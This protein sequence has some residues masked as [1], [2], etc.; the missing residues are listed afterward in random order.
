MTKI[1][2]AIV[3]LCGLVLTGNGAE[4]ISNGGLEQIGSNGYPSG[5]KKFCEDPLS[6]DVGALQLMGNPS[7]SLVAS[8]AHAGKNS[9]WVNIP[10]PKPAIGGWAV[11]LA[12]KPKTLYRFSCWAKIEGKVSACVALNQFQ[13]DGQTRAAQNTIAINS[14]RWQKVELDFESH[15][16][17]VGLQIVGT[18]YQSAG[19]AWFDD[20]SLQELVLT[21]G[22]A[23][24]AVEDET[25]YTKLTTQVVTPHIAWAN[26]SAAGPIKVLAF[27]ANR[28]VVELAQR[29]SLDFTTWRKFADDDKMDRVYYGP[30]KRGNFAS[31]QELKAKLGKPYDVILVGTFDWATLPEVIRKEALAKVQAGAG[32]VFIR[33]PKD[34]PLEPFKEK[35]VAIPPLLSVGIPYAGLT[36]LDL[37]AQGKEWL[38]C[39]TCGK[40]RVAIVDYQNEK[41]GFWECERSFRRGRGCPF[42]PDVTYDYRAKPLYYEYYQSL[43]ARLVMWAAQKEGP[44]TFAQL[45]FA[46]GRLQAS[47]TNTGAVQ[48]GVSTEIVVRDP[49][50]QVEFTRTKPLELREGSNEFTAEIPPL[51]SGPHFADLWMKKNGQVLAWGS[52]Y[53]QTTSDITIAAIRTTKLSYKPEETVEGTVTF[54]KELPETAKVKLQLVDSLGRLLEEK[55]TVGKGEKEMPFQFTLRGAVAILHQVKAALLDGDNRVV[56]EKTIDV[57]CRRP[58]VTGDDFQFWF[59]AS[60][61]N[62]NFYNRYALQDFYNRGFDVAYVGYLYAQPANQLTGCLMNTVRPNLDLAL[63]AFSLACWNAG[64]DPT[65]TVSPRCLTAKPFRENMFRVLRQHASVAR[66]YPVYAYSLGDECG[67]AGYGQDFCFS[68]TCLAFIRNYLKSVYGDLAQLNQEWG[69][70]F[71]A[72]DQVKCLTLAEAKK[73]GNFAP[74]V[75]LRMAMEEMFAGLIKESGDVLREKDPDARVGLE[76][77]HG[78]RIPTCGEDSFNGYD[79]GKIVPRGNYW[80]PYF[81]YYPGIEFIRSFAASNTILQTYTQPFEDFPK[82]Y[83]EDTWQNEKTDRFVPWYDLLHGMNST[84]YWGVMG[85]DW[86]GFYSPDYRPTPWAAPITETIREIKR[87]A[88]M[89]LVRSRR[90]HDRIAIHYSPASFHVGTF[91]G[92]K[93]RQ[94]SPQAFCHLLEDLGLQYDFISK[95]QMAQGKLSEYKA[96]ILPYSRAIDARE[97]EAIRQFAALGGALI[98]DGEAGVIRIHPQIFLRDFDFHVIV[99]FRNDIQ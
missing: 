31:L 73:S 61:A 65:A 68:P 49:E 7:N 22:A 82:G 30:R 59:W 64:S 78:G 29:L 47:V 12:I 32:L 16:K 83:F 85:M 98:A 23:T 66:D 75:D 26:P 36:V 21:A 62:N 71:T 10:G 90:M 91:L 51:K 50:G 76:G 46:D 89:L 19:Q 80:G 74:W 11:R 25:P 84:I 43:L 37:D 40:G 87:G 14:N 38:K 45:S 69:T 96:L 44:V 57:I 81:H 2:L 52:T 97:A 60:Q 3:L 48:T 54:N 58:P 79:F 6:V 53:F 28:E 88:G 70:T 86:Y 17:T 56:C 63:F 34:S 55:E 27:P 1:N 5:W 72:W 13:A 94:E 39:F 41:F 93:E 4:L 24:N 8:D 42:T 15:P 35:A 67:L 33:P 9:L 20:F 99:Q 18:I 77:I 95:E 92:S